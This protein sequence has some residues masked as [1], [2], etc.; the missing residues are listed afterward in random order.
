MIDDLTKG[1][2]IALGEEMK[3]YEAPWPEYG[4]MLKV[5]VARADWKAVQKVMDWI[6]DQSGRKEKPLIEYLRGIVREEAK[7]ASAEGTSA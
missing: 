6:L 2:L 3:Q 5:A 1:E 7:T 4:A